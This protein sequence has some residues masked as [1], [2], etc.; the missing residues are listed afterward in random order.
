MASARIPY[1]PNTPLGVKIRAYV[2]AMVE[3]R[4]NGA[5]LA[6]ILDKYV[7]DNAG[8]A[9]DSG[10]PAAS[11]PLVKN[12]VNASQAELGTVTT[13]ALAVGAQTNCRQ[14]ADAMG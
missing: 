14:L 8:I 12:M 10:I 5:E 3:A 4:K 2:S 1:D 11:V 7:D 6:R 13:A 9:T